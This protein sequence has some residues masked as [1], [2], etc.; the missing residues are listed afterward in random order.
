MKKHSDLPLEHLLFMKGHIRG[1]NSSVER[2]RVSATLPHFLEWSII[3]FSCIQAYWHYAVTFCSFG[4]MEF[5][6]NSAFINFLRSGA[7]SSPTP[8]RSWGEFRLFR[9]I[10][11]Q[12]P[13]R[14]KEIL[15]FRMRLG[16]R[17]QVEF[18][19]LAEVCEFVPSERSLLQLRCSL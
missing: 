11:I 7:P 10:R 5:A 17:G 4:A 8:I 12:L 6:L 19:K 15:Q 9:E 3:M 1:T 2:W 14:E 18:C 13:A 16:E